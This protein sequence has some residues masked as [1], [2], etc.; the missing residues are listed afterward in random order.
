MTN[1]LLDALS[2]A[3][4]SLMTGAR[5]AGPSSSMIDALLDA[6]PTRPQFNP[7][8]LNNLAWTV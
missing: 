1:A 6:L 7:V 5:L 4:S 2:T 3:P 8:S